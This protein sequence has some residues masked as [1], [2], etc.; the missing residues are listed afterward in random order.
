MNQEEQ[1]KGEAIQIILYEKK[2]LCL[3]K[4]RKKIKP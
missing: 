1:R 4:V 2:N 3:I